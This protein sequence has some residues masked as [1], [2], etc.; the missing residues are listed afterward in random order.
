MSEF[1]AF[2]SFPRMREPTPTSFPRM[3]EPTPTSFPRMRE[4]SDRA[5]YTGFP[6]LRE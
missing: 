5:H 1:R 3:R 6:P 4:P 2:P